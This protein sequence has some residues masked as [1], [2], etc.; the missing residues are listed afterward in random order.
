MKYVFLSEGELRELI[1]E[2]VAG[3]AKPEPVQKSRFSMDEAIEYLADNGYKISKST[4]YQYTSKGTIKFNRYGGRQ[5][6][7]TIEQL[8]EFLERMSD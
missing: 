7:F 3:I 2:A 4:L 5:I 8:D 1:I 6:V